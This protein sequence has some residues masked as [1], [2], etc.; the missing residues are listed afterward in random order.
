MG[1]RLGIDT[2][3][4]FTDLALV[5]DER[6]LV[7]VG[8]LP[9][10]PGDPSAAILAGL[11]QLL[12]EH[13]LAPADLRYLGHGTTVGTNAV[14]EGAFAPTGLLTTDG[15]RDLLELARQRRPD[16]Y[17]L[18][19]PKPTPIVPRE[20][21]LEVRER[22]AAD[23]SVVRPLDEAA[24]RALL[25]QL[26]AAG[27]EAL[28]ICLLHAYANPAHERRLL[29]LAREELPGVAV[30]LSSEV[31]PEWREYERCATTCL[32]AAL[33]PVM[34]RYLGRFDRAVRARGLAA[35]ARVM[36]SNGGVISAAAAGER[37][38]ATLFSG[39]SAGVI[40]AV[41]LAG[42]AGER[43]LIS[44]DMGGTSTDVCL[45]R[46]GQPPL[47]H[48][49]ELAGRPV[50]GTML[51]IHSVGAG[52]GSI[53]WVDP[54]GLLKVGPRSAGAQPGPAC[55]GQG[56]Q[57]PTVT[58][59]NVALGRL[60]PEAL[61]GGRMPIDADAA[62]RALAERLG[63]PLGF[64]AVAAARGVLAILQ[65]NLVRAVR[66]ISVE[67]GYDPRDF[68]LVAFGGA[69]PLHAARLAR[70]LGLRRV[71]VPPSPGVLCALGLLTADRRSDFGLT[72]LAPVDAG[73]LPAIRS[74]FAELEARAE[75]WLARE[76]LTAAEVRF[77]RLAELRYRRQ[78]YELPVPVP[79]GELDEA[80][81]AHV[82]AGFHAEHER[83]YGYAVPGEPVHV[84]TV[85]LTVVAPVPPLP[86]RPASASGRPAEPS[87][88]RLVY[89]EE[90]D[91]FLACPIY[92]RERL[93]P[94]Q[95]LAG[96]AI[97]EQ[98]DATTLLLPGQRARVDPFGNLILEEA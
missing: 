48:G 88:Q 53:G 20:R 9:S 94:G 44:F 51:D 56:G 96:P 68:T 18:D 17:D 36:Q 32:N 98:L 41:R 60:H 11:E 27:I 65:A 71:L 42:Q 10:S 67:R 30:S 25:R 23:G 14:L 89:F 15:F 39:P 45:V 70:D 64:D 22:L 49:R 66:V 85:R 92:Q 19:R 69:G 93:Q 91:D 21:R 61:L 33:V 62:R 83:A 38:V 8:K 7:G 77:E 59:A 82:A 75:A 80:A 37:P 58:D 72:C 97:V 1:W 73:G 57:E 31:L 28:A 13:G 5:D 50:H 34:Q 29:E 76:G 2:G 35:G 90:A 4:T 95:A 79:P 46:G 6:G 55:Y 81:L 86:A 43:D 3:G 52:G 26:G 24:A 87:G 12:A 78:D 74:A 40:G 54:G 47:V 63:G 16:L 84:V